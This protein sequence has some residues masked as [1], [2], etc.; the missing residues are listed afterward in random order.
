V[1]STA[2]VQTLVEG[3]PVPTATPPDT[4]APPNAGGASPFASASAADLD[5]LARRLT[6]PLLRRVR[7]QLLVDRERRGVRADL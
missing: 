5:E 6:A 3:P 7:G 1:R 2:T 4:A